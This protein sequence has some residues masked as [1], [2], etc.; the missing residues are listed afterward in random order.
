VPRPRQGP[1][2]SGPSSSGPREALHA[3]QVE[4][5]R[6]R[7]LS[8]M[9][10]AAEAGRSRPRKG[11]RKQLGRGIAGTRQPAGDSRSRAGPADYRR[12]RGKGQPAH[13]EG[14]DQRPRAGP[15]SCGKIRGREDRRRGRRTGGEKIAGQDCG[16]QETGLDRLSAPLDDVPGGGRAEV[17]DRCPLSLPVRLLLARKNELCCC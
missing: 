17:F 11:R 12:E 3:P 10:V 9:G 5:L 14:G 4:K 1:E 13:Q 6:P 7:Q 8:R 15:P 16:S 2:I